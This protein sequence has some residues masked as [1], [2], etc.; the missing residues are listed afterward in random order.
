MHKRVRINENISSSSFSEE[1]EEE[2]EELSS[3]NY[4]SSSEEV[5]ADVIEINATAL[6]L[7]N[8]APTWTTG[9]AKDIVPLI[10]AARAAPS[11]MCDDDWDRLMWLFFI[12]MGT[13]SMV[14]DD[15]PLS[16]AYVETQ[17]Q[18]SKAGLLNGKIND[19]LLFGIM[20]SVGFGCMTNYTSGDNTIEWA[21]KLGHPRA[22][23]LDYVHANWPCHNQYVPYGT[24]EPK[25]IVHRWTRLSDKRRIKTI[26]LMRYRSNLWWSIPKDVLY[27]I[28]SWIVTK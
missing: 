14:L 1:E 12:Y 2:D 25:Y 18:V 23:Y 3:S 7:R 13:P 26:L 27:L 10:K 22:V 17:F 24:W 15:I 28:I 11:G 8:T 19:L 4:S 6:R 20:T 16:T 9:Y 21:R 5:G